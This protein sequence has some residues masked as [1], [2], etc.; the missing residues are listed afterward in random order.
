MKKL[1]ALLLALALIPTAAFAEVKTASGTADGYGGPI[2][3]TL[4][5]EEGKLINVEVTGEKETIG[6]GTLAMDKMPQEMI[7]TNS[8]N[9]DVVTGATYT[10]EGVLKAAEAA[11]AALGVE[12]VPVEKSTAAAALEPVYTDVLVIGAGG[13]GLAAAAPAMDEGAENVILVEML[14][15]TGGSTALSGGVMTRSAIEGD[16]EG[17]M[18]ADEMHQYFMDISK[19]MADPEVVR[20]YV[21]HSGEDQPWAFSMGDGV[22][23]TARY[24]VI[25]E[26]IMAII[27]VGNATGAATGIFLTQAMEQGVRERGV[28]LRL[29]TE[30][31]ELIVENGRVVGAKVK[32]K[33][34]EYPI[35]AK[36]GV[37]L[38][39]GGF[40]QNKELVEQ[41]GSPNADTVLVKCTAG[42]TG[43]GLVMARDIGAKVQFGDFWDTIGYH[44]L[45][46]SGY[47]NR[48]NMVLINADG[49]R[50]YRE[51]GQLP[52]MYTEMCRQIADGKIKFFFLSDSNL[53]PEFANLEAKI[54]AVKLDTFEDL[55]AYT[56]CDAEILRKT[57]EDY[58]ANKGK[59]DPQTGKDAEY[60]MGL[61]APYHCVDTTV[62][63]VATIGGLL[64]DKDAQVLD[65]NDQP[66]PG[67]YA[68][69][70]VA[71]A[72]FYYD[73]YS[74]CGSA[75]QHAVTFGRIAARNAVAN[76]K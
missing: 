20:A 44:T 71:N 16:P 37:I 50:F 15:F 17:T 14:S 66:I 47:R 34:G 8:V 59:V 39:T 65:S 12:L 60:M 22:Q 73:T 7:D 68:A 35:Y 43:T 55:V 1:M 64:T 11:V 72:S 26:H 52:F 9:V 46:A 57:L 58:N 32:S 23:Q 62:L 24:H 67:L 49:E 18:G 13:T 3:V 40:A 25:P 4:S 6:I 21:D 36:G 19:N 45:A 75:V 33:D 2:N 31:K 76:L 10:S 41:Y 69:G 74:T 27:P 28:D 61:E 63:R 51:D 42:A 54:P 5:V 38:A 48:L 56:G 70:E 53:E 30:A 29:E